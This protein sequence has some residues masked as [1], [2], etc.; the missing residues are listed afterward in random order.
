MASI[1]ELTRDEEGRLSLTGAR[2]KTA[3]LGATG[4]VGQQLIRMLK[5]HPWFDVVALAA[6]HNS[7]GQSYRRAMDGRWSMNFEM[8]EHLAAQEVYDVREVDRIARGVDVAFCALNLDKESIRRL[9]HSYAERGVWVTSNNSAFRE[10]A[11]VPMV[12]PA[13][14]PQ[15]LYVIGAQRAARGYETGAIL[16]KSNCSIQSYVI[17]LEPLREFGI[18]K[19]MVHSEQAIS[20]AGKTFQTWPEMERNLIPLINGEEKKS[21]TEP[22]KIWG[23]VGGDGIASSSSGPKIRARCVRVAVQD[24]HTAYVLVQFKNTPSK[25]EILSRWERYARSQDLPSAPRKLIHY[26]TE[27]DRPQPLLDVMRENGMAVSIGQLEVDETDGLVSFTALTHNVLLG[28]AG[29]AVWATEAALAR[30]LLYRRV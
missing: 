23:T 27:P 17:A 12:I 21:E 11:F 3:V 29:G 4:I 9:E 8:P 5:A 26:L 1:A 10:D 7:A 2:L 24:G 20:G 6:S 25:G 15:H 30:G 13:V 19:I 16:V 18:E 22:L 14:N 28:A